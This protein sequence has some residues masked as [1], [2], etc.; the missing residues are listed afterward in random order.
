M[1]SGTTFADRYAVDSAAPWGVPG[2]TAWTAR[3]TRLDAPVTLLV[4][5]SD[6]SDEVLAAL[7]RVRGSRVANVA[8]IVDVGVAAVPGLGKG[9]RRA[10]AAVE[11][12]PTPHL[13]TVLDAHVLPVPF[14]RLVLRGAGAALVAADAAGLHHGA[15]TVDSIG[16]TTRGRVVVAGAGLAAAFGRG[17]TAAHSPDA[18]TEADA[19]SL[20]A[21]F[22]HAILGAESF[23]DADAPL[24]EELTK[25][26]RRIVA[27][28]RR[29]RGPA[30]VA[31]LL[32]DLGPTGGVTLSGLRTQLRTLER[33]AAEEAAQAEADAL[34][35]ELALAESLRLH[36]LATEALS[37]DATPRE[38]DEW[39]LEHLLEVEKA[40]EVPTLAE[41][42]LDL[43]HRRFPR[44]ARIT[45]YLE[46]AH[47]RALGGP[48]VNGSRWTV[49]AL[50][51]L[52][53]VLSVVAVE[54]FR[55]PFVPTF[56]LKNPPPQ[57]YPSYTF[58]PSPTDVTPSP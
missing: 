28:A 7:T 13:A 24:P 38:L 31:A 44:S 47:E 54:I 48:R 20:A 5:E 41:A 57:S 33:V 39:E 25:A 3:D 15:L 51:V 32:G 50:L 9:A 22:A 46:A 18:A 40:E 35:E 49:L 58:S 36:E 17:G 8:R 23:D 29:D 19:A 53:S 55:S 10:Y 26:E 42:F 6:H 12:L 37:E 45:G 34:A 43:L 56:D 52:V 21:V 2:A 14:A 16:L 4:A 11:A 27:L 30:S 1:L